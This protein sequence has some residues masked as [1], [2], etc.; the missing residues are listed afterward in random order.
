M[1]FLADNAVTG[2]KIVS[3]LNQ[4]QN[5]TSN[6]TETTAKVQSGWGRM[7]FM[8]QNAYM[9]ESVTFPQAFSSIPLVIVSH[10]GDRTAAQGSGSYGGGGNNIHGQVYGACYNITT[11]GFMAKAGTSAA[12]GNYSA[13]DTIYYQWFA[14]GA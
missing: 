12:G 9:A 13:G 14:I 4:R 7:T 5:D 10:G 6:V 3:Y 8:G 2:Q 1:V 11:T